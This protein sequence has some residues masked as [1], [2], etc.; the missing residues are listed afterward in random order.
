MLIVSIRRAVLTKRWRTDPTLPDP[1]YI[2]VQQPGISYVIVSTADEYNDTAG[3]SPDR[4]AKMYKSLQRNLDKL[5]ESFDFSA[6]SAEARTEMSVRK[7]ISQT[8]VLSGMHMA[9]DLR[10]T[11]D[12][13]IAKAIKKIGKH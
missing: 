11:M 12:E 5:F 8:L 7:A 10:T 1:F 13:E 6:L 2:R 9:L 3:H 4:I